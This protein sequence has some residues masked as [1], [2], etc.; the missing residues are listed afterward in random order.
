MYKHDIYTQL[1]KM[2]E[3]T[4]Q[5]LKESSQQLEETTTVLGTTQTKL[6]QVQQ[7]LKQ[8]KLEKKQKEFLVQ[9]H[10][11]TEQILLDEAGKVHP[12]NSHS[13]LV[14]TL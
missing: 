5:E 11:K 12:Y 4:S 2:F 7:N 1:S 10:V 3:Y 13:F 8:T 9:Q 6:T 14:T